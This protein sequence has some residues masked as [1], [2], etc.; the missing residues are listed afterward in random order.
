MASKYPWIISY[1]APLLKFSDPPIVPAREPEI[2]KRG[3][4]R[5]KAL[6]TEPL[7][8][9]LQKGPTKKRHLGQLLKAIAEIN[10]RNKKLVT[11]TSIARV[12][13]THP[14]YK[15]LGYKHLGK[16]QP[17]HDVRQAI[18]WVIRLLRVVPPE[19][20]VERFGIA[21]PPAM[22]DKFL[23][24]RAFEYLRHYLAQLSAKKA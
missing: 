9:F 8:E 11:N 7:S 22:T 23:R 19:N 13:Q 12:L 17:Q 6:S 5:P 20:W 2:T 24:E 16:D 4:G 10:S 15:H 1:A 21:P 14:E 18:Q 3:P